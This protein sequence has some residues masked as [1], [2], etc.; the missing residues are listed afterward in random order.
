MAF[1]TGGTHSYN[2][3]V[4]HEIPSAE[5]SDPNDAKPGQRAQGDS[6]KTSFLKTMMTECFI[7]IRVTV[8]S[9]P[10]AHLTCAH[11]GD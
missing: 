11:P 6:Q 3:L 9:A 4:K 5:L 10:A 2:L 8:W 7:T 1:A